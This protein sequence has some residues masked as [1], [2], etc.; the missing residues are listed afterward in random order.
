MMGM[1]HPM[2]DHMRSLQYREENGRLPDD[3]YFPTDED[4]MSDPETLEIIGMVQDQYARNNAN[5]REETLRHEN[6]A[7]RQIIEDNGLPLPEDV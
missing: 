4:D 1:E 2:S 3:V 6:A 7:L 5:R